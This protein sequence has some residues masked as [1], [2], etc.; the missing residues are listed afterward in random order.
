MNSTQCLAEYKTFW[1]T[2]Y[3]LGK[4][5]KHI[6]HKVTAPSPFAFR[7]S[8]LAS[9]SLC[10]VFSMSSCFQRE[11][12]IPGGCSQVIFKTII[13]L[14]SLVAQMV[15]NLPAM[16]ETWVWSLG[17]E[18]PWRRAWQPTPVLLPGESHG[19]RSLVGYSPC[20]H[21]ELEATEQLTLSLFHHP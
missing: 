16:Q 15:K 5:K 17:Q 8:F 19:Q 6:K 9:C 4:L 2:S 3:P 10:S 20:G 14:A 7:T 11:V 13:L 21:K 1:P 12:L 18:D